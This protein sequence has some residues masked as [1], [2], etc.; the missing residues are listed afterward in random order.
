MT[1]LFLLLTVLALLAL[2]IVQGVILNKL[3]GR[4]NT[5]EDEVY[6]LQGQMGL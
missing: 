6:M 5:L 1:E 4:I 2:A 3:H